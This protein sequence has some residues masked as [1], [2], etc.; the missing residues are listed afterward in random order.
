[1]LGQAEQAATVLNIA[2]K[3]LL[4][5]G[6]LGRLDRNASRVTGAIGVQ[7]IA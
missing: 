5:H 4:N 1:M 7:A 6:G 3:Q 2:G